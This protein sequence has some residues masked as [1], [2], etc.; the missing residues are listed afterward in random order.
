MSK[1]KGS[2]R[3]VKV[4]IWGLIDM[5]LFNNIP[6]QMKIEFV[7]FTVLWLNVFLAKTGV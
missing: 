6:Q 2:I 3:T 5:L 1:A 7:Y 4:W